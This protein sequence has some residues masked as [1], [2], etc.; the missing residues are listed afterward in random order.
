MAGSKLKPT[1]ILRMAWGLVRIRAVYFLHE[2]PSGRP[3]LAAQISAAV[4][5][6]TLTAPFFFS[7]CAA[8]F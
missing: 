7:A 4:Q 3:R 2:W 5:A 8:L 1:D 6:R